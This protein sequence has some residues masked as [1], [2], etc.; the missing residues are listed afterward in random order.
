MKTIDGIE[1]ADDELRS[2]CEQVPNNKCNRT[3]CC[4]FHH[5]C[6]DVVEYI[7]SLPED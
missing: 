6:D 4:G 1:Y 2:A 3:Y 7:R 5:T